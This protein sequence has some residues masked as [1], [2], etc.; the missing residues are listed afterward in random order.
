MSI[1]VLISAFLALLVAFAV[2]EYAHGLMAYKLGDPTAKYEGRLTLNPLV[3]LDPIGSLVMLFT[4]MMSHGQLVYGWAKP[5]MINRDNFRKPILDAALVAFAGPFSNFVLAFLG[6][7]PLLLG[8][9]HEPLL[10]TF[11]YVFVLANT[12][13]GLF[14]LIPCP[15]LDGWKIVQVVVPRTF[16]YQMQDWEEAAGMWAVIILFVGFQFIGDPIFQPVL[17]T[18]VG[19]FTGT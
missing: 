12:G 17:R 3:H 10:I 16:A 7:L 9:V 11:F 15:P 18:L 1:T 14:N 13:F 2:H 8:L 19:L 5:V 4:I 6:G